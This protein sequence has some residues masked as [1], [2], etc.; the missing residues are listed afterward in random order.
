MKEELVRKA[1][2]AGLMLTPDLLEKLDDNKLEEM[3][4]EARDRDKTFLTRQETQSCSKIMVKVLR[5]SPKK[6]LTPND[7]VSYYN[8]KYEGIRKFLLK[9]LDAVSINKVREGH[10]ELSIIG[11]VRELTQRGFVLE[12]PTGE[13]E[14]LSKNQPDTDDVIGVKGIARE[15]KFMEKEIIVPDV[16]LDSQLKRIRNISLF[17]TT[18]LTEKAKPLI[19]STNFTLIPFIETGILNEKEEKQ[20]ITNLTNPTQITISSMGNEVNI[21]VYKPTEEIDETRAKD[22]LRKRHLSPGR[23]NILGPEDC[24]LIDNMPD[25]FWLISPKKFLENYKGVTII[26]CQFPN[27]AK[28]NLETREVEFKQV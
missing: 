11:M 9:K 10:E 8:N 28:V 12:D 3:I 19:H 20:T 21:L 6:R 2:E 18:S 5:L 1:L 22:Y 16:P 23:N 7:F 26:S 14:V 15:G 24:F 13:I 27:A 25:I 4:T 17:L